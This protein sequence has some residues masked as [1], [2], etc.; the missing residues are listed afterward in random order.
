M[1]RKIDG[2]EIESQ[3]AEY[4]VEFIGTDGETWQSAFSDEGEAHLL[5]TLLDGEVIVRAHFVS[6]WTPPLEAM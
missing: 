4:G 3:D 5:A 6:A 1:A 2:L